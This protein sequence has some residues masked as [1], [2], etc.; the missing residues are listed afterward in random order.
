MLEP[1]RN[2]ASVRVGRGW[3]SRAGFAKKAARPRKARP[4]YPWK[5]P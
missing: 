4:S 2:E 5:L 3:C 1:S